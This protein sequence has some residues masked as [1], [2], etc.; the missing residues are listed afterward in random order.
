MYS[1]NPKNMTIEQ[2]NDLI[3]D[4]LEATKTDL[5]TANYVIELYS[6]LA[7]LLGRELRNCTKENID[8]K[9]RNEYLIKN[10]GKWWELSS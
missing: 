9:R 10:K 6:Q 5:K 1:F 3:I 2:I 4:S 8:L 7:L